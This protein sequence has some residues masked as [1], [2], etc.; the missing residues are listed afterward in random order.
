MP[1]QRMKVICLLLIMGFIFL[2]IPTNEAEGNNEPHTV[3]IGPF[4]D[5]R[6]DAIPGVNI[7]FTLN[8]SQY[9][10]LTGVDGK[11]T[12]ILPKPLPNG[13]EISARRWDVEIKWSWYDEEIPNYGLAPP[14][15]HHHD[16]D[17]SCLIIIIAISI[18][19]LILIIIVIYSIDLGVKNQNRPGDVNNEN[20]IDKDELDEEKKEET[21]PEPKP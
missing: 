15:P 16:S 9:S 21:K 12:F 6:N 11:A 8:G 17:Y 7:S 4:I 5:N 18:I 1:I 3:V 13:T 19:V 14:I 20:N 2:L 10:N